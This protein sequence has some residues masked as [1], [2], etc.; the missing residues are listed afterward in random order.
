MTHTKV[1]ATKEDTEKLFSLVRKG[2]M[3]GDRIMVF[4]VGEGLR[5][6]SAT[7]N[8][9]KVCHQLALDYG[10]PEISGYYGISEDGEFLRT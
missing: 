2:W 1:F 4:S 9:R 8:A 5:K 6:D 7:V 3:S 10:L